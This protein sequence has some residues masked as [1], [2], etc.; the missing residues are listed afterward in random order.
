MEPPKWIKIQGSEHTARRK[1]GTYDLL[2][3]EEYLN[4]MIAQGWRPIRVRKGRDFT[5]VPCEPGEYLCRIAIILNKQRAVEFGGLLANDGVIIVEQQNQGGRQDGVIALK[6]AA[7]GTFDLVADID[8]CLAEY[9]KRR[10]YNLGLAIV[11]LVGTI[12]VVASAI[13]VALMGGF[14]PFAWDDFRTYNSILMPLGAILM[15]CSS[16]VVWSPVRR[17]NKAIARLRA[18]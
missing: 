16:F 11:V 18:K 5:F 6:P 2:A 17:Y 12:F 4:E 13:F 14:K 3:L 9:K 1:N 10:G 8:T 15:V 7:H